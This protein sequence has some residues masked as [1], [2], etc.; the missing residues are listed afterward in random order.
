M[1]D[2]LVELTLNTH[3][4]QILKIYSYITICKN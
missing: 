3:T 2:N 1:S 4:H